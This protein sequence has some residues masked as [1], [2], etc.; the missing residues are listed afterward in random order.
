LGFRFD[1]RPP[2]DFDDLRDDG[3]SESPKSVHPSGNPMSHSTHV[4]F[5]APPAT[6]FSG[7]L[8]RPYWLGPPLLLASCTVGVGYIAA[9]VAKLMPVLL[10]V[11]LA[12]S[13]P[14]ADAFG[15]GH[16]AGTLPCDF[17]TS[18]PAIA[19]ASPRLACP[20]SQAR[21]HNRT[22]PSHGIWLA[23]G[24]GHNPDSVPAVRRTNGW[25]WNNVPFRIKPER[26]KVAENGVQP[27]RSESWDVLNNRPS[28]SYVAKYPS[29]LVPKTRPRSCEASTFACN[30][31][32]LAG[33]P[34]ADEIDW[35]ISVGGWEGSHVTV[36]RHVGPMLGEDAR[37]IV[38]YLHLPLAGHAS[39]F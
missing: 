8:F 10:R 18:R 24:V 5:N 30:A 17:R 38:I 27:P 28:G 31:D 23:L 22:V 13:G 21:R 7:K 35:P 29:K 26:G 12:K 9:A 14:A 32:V 33:E 2:D 37:G 3:V 19:L 15:V 20:S 34:A 25:S 4:G 6:A 11:F 36:A 16:I 39:T 1:D